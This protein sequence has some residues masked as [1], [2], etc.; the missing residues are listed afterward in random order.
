M[1]HSHGGRVGSVSE[2]GWRRWL[3]I[4]QLTDE[5]WEAYQQRKRE[6][7]QQRCAPHDWNHGMT[8]T[9]MPRGL[10]KPHMSTE[11]LDSC[12]VYDTPITAWS[13]FSDTCT[14]GRQIGTRV[15]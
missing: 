10:C 6:Q 4:R 1:K 14:S 12:V 15:I 8:F 9:C 3:P 11:M 2:L 7:F 13:R 5:E